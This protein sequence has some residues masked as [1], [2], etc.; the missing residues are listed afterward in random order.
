MGVEIIMNIQKI[1]I[2][3]SNYKSSNR[4]KFLNSEEV[5]STEVDIILKAK[6][7]IHIAKYSFNSMLLANL[8]VQ[9]AREG[10]KVRVVIDPFSL[11]SG[12]K[13]WEKRKYVVEY[14]KSN[15]VE[16]QIFPVVPL[17][18]FVSPMETNTYVLQS[19]N[20]S[21][22][23]DY[24]TKNNYQLM[25]AKYVSV[26]GKRAVISGVNWSDNSF[27][28]T[29]AGIFVEGKVIDDLEKFFWVLFKKSG[30]TDFEYIPRAEEVGNSN[31]S[32][33]VA[34]KDIPNTNYAE[35]VY[36]AVKNAQKMIHVSA[37]VLSDPYLI[38]LLIEAH[39]RGVEVKV[40]MDPN[41]SPSYTNPN[42]NTEKKLKEAGIIPRWYKVQNYNTSL[43]NFLHTKMLIAD[44][45]LIIGSG[46][47]SYRG[48]RINHEVG[49]QTDDPNTVSEAI[50]YFLK[51]WK[52]NTTIAPMNYDVNYS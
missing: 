36:N 25:H 8:L 7:T 42:Y 1:D 30:G 35:A 15:G 28:N 21:K 6:E 22:Q 45:T 47:F 20:E 27:K 38:K 52:E 33:L 32:L 18:D 17:R 3:R 29:D 14:L 19:D 12:G 40:I 10:V 26:D 34:D 39:N 50:K 43:G 16:V 9:K 41:N 4:L 49:I 11:I 23:E 5:I 51:I 44:N 46:N 2:S 37:F 24:E 31:A 48:L 13:E